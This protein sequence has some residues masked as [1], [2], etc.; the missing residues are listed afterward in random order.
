MQI[1][2]FILVFTLFYLSFN[3]I[4]S[5][6]IHLLEKKTLQ[7]FRMRYR[8][9]LSKSMFVSLVNSFCTYRQIR[10]S[11][12]IVGLYFVLSE[13][14]NESESESDSKLELVELE[15]LELKELKLALESVGVL[16]SGA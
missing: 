6:E 10:K 13:H 16:L 14:K 4:F 2:I 3:S 1:K 7:L 11:F 15:K 9:H 8:T 12:V 5:V